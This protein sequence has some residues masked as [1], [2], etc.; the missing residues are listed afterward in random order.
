MP[1]STPCRASQCAS[2]PCSP[3]IA[4]PS[5]NGTR[6]VLWEY[7]Q[8]KWG[9]TAVPS[10]G[11]RLPYLGDDTHPRTTSGYARTVRHA[12][13][14]SHALVYTQTGPHALALHPV[15]LGDGKLVVAL[16]AGF[17]AVVC[18]LVI[19]IVLMI[20]R[21]RSVRAADAAPGLRTP[22]VAE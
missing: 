4:G 20:R 17:G 13:T 10:V 2:G 12:R 11:T 15:A 6:R 19:C 5:L 3:H 7:S 9:T 16:A 21:L 8:P 18:V 14:R 1:L 22:L